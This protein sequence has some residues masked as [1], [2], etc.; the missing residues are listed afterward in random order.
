M[1][2]KTNGRVPCL[3][4]KNNFCSAYKYQFLGSTCVPKFD[5]EKGFSLSVEPDFTEA[6]NPRC[7]LE[8]LEL[9]WGGLSSNEDSRQTTN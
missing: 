8:I 9:K 1:R 6:C 7:P 2:V 5:F 3:T 4:D